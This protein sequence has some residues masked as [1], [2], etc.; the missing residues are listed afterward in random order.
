MKQGLP[1]G[2]TLLSALFC[3]SLVAEAQVRPGETS[4]KRAGY[5]HSNGY[6]HFQRSTDGSDGLL[7]FTVSPIRNYITGVTDR[8]SHEHD[9]PAFA[10]AHG[11]SDYQVLVSAQEEEGIISPNLMGFNIVY[12]KTKDIQWKNGRGPI[13][14]LL[15]KIGTQ[16]LRWPAGTVV[17]NYHWDNL[18][19]QGWSDT[20][21]P[22]FD[23]SKNPEPSQFMDLDEY[24]STVKQMGIEPLIGVNMGSGK[25]YDRVEDGIDE[26]KALVQYCI[27]QG[28]RVKYYYLGNEPYHDTAN[29]T[30]TAEEYA[31]Q[32][33]L[34]ADAMREI[35]PTIKTI[36]NT[37]PNNDGY[38]RT[39]LR[40]AGANIDYVDVHYY[41]RFFDATFENWKA[42]P[43]MVHHT[44]S[45]YR[46]QRPHYKSIFQETGH[47][48]IE[49]VT[50]EWNTGPH[51]RAGHERPSEAEVA[52][53]VSEQFTQFIQSGV[54][55][56]TFWPLSWPGNPAWANR[57]LVNPEKEYRPNKVYDMFALF[58]DA[59]GQQKVNSST[60]ADRMISLA[61]KS[62]DGGTMWLY[63]INKTLENRAVD[64]SISIDGFDV[65]EY[66]AVG[67]ESTDA[68]HGALNV[69]EM[70]IKEVD[71][72]IL[73]SMPQFS[74]AKI[75]LEQ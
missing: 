53:M 2:F 52:L 61:V 5:H 14:A 15:S 16:Q 21:S 23:P 4:K 36:I 9:A 1:L 49:L 22:T 34:Y 66:G 7:S 47:P 43:V 71:S 69:E 44:K 63:L 75:T 3:F 37:H 74:F 48:D 59:L 13:P 33:N 29:Y 64:V 8:L 17:T 11:S 26:A 50:L 40:R 18:T 39:I 6:I 32:V 46:D 67:F 19:G 65:A 62:R 57:M 10:D 28:V 51:V 45:P 54:H 60:S 70:G 24:L 38:L 35:D 68:T 25:K 41:W 12:S 72:G 73:I 42:E 27:D 31:E 55:M 30:F 20:W 56:A 58:T